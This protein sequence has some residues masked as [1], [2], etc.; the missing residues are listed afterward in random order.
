MERSPDEREPNLPGGQA[1]AEVVRVGDTV[2]RTAGR[3]T[4]AVHALLRHLEAKGFAGAPR[5]LG[6]DT[7]KR[8]ILSYI[9]GTPGTLPW[10]PALRAD[11]GLASAVRLVAEFHDAIVDFDP[12]ADTQWADGSSELRPGQIV[13]HRDL[14]PHNIVWRE[15]GAVAIIDWDFAGPGDPLDDVAFLAFTTVPMRDDAYCAACGFEDVPDR[16]RRL[17]LICETYGRGATPAD[18]IARAERHHENDIEEIETFGA[19]GLSPW[20][21][22]LEH[23]LHQS[24][25]GMLLWMRANHELLISP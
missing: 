9:P 24:I 18:L 2:R 20:A 25:R 5:A 12:P 16:A 6:I 1:T 19:E 11:R 22:F 14:G 10:P 4:L 17:R 13:C 7:R 8:E 21:A 23:N 3:W 15:D